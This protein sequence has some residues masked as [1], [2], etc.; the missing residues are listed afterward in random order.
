M[1]LYEALY[2]RKR[3]SLMCWEEV[4]E[5][6]LARLELV[7]ITSEK[8][9]II[10]KRLKTAF[11][12]Q[13]SYASPKWK[14]VDF[15]VGEYVFLKVSPMRGV[16]CFGKK[17]KFPLDI[18]R[19][20]KIIN[21]IGEVAYK[22]DLLP[23]FL[24]VHQVFHKSMLRKYISD[25]SHVLQ[26][27]YVEVSEYL[28][29]KEQPVRLVDTQVHQLHFKIISMVKVLWRNHSSEECTW[30]TKQEMRSVYPRLFQS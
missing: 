11:N 25:S 16:I 5:R 18:V 24:H 20:F 6:K 7:H 4:S 22:L 13:K 29:Y 19:P 8:I 27:Q 21:K 30:E 9:S 15:S 1:A 14:H 10:C 23:N 3:R 2:G 26:P 28:T 12:R 17:G